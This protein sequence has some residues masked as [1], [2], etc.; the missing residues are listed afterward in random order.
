MMNR[1]YIYLLVCCLPLY[2]FGQSVPAL[3]HSADMEI[4]FNTGYGSYL[5]SDLKGL[6]NYFLSDNPLSAVN[7]ESFPDYFNYTIRIGKKNP[8][9]KTFT[10]FI[11]GLMST[12]ARNSI[13][14]Y[15]GK[16]TMDI[17]CQ[18]IHLGYYVKKELLSCDVF[19]LPLKMGCLLNGSVIYSMVDLREKLYLNDYGN[20]INENYAFKSTGICAE[21]QLYLNYMFLKDMGFELTAGAAANLSTALYYNNMQNVVKIGN[22]MWY[23]NW[24]GYRLSAGIVL[25]L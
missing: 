12:G 11:L 3:Q 7:T 13:A 15:S 4:S 19:K 10:G 14:D 6:Q 5:M 24:T 20:V 1:I 16:Y 17:K 2:L 22:K 23:P 8:A 9:T 18:G 21:P 25:H